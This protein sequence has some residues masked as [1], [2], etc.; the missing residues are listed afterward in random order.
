MSLSAPKQIV[1]IISV[2]LAVLGVLSIY[3]IFGVGVPGSTLLLAGY[4]LLLLGNLLK[5]L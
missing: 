2:V 3:G 4:V 1:F 5:G